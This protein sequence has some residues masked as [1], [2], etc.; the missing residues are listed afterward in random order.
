MPRYVK[1]KRSMAETR[2]ANYGG[3]RLRIDVEEVRGDGWD[4]HLFVYRRRPVNIYTGEERDI[5]VAVAGPAQL[6]DYPAGQPDPDQGW[7]YYRLP[8]AIYDVISSQTAEE[9]W[10]TAEEQINTLMEALNRLDTYSQVT[11]LWYPSDPD[12]P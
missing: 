11:E 10:L 4:T 12:T 3:Y 1:L 6:A 9:I 5:C 8:Y 7:P 2:L